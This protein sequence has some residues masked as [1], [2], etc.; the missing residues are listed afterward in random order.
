MRI[1][2]QRLD[3]V[4]IL[5]AQVVENIPNAPDNAIVGKLAT[6]DTAKQHYLL[7]MRGIPNQCNRTMRDNLRQT[8]PCEERKFLH[9]LHLTK[10]VL[11]NWCKIL[12]QFQYMSGSSNRVG[13]SYLIQPYKFIWTS[14]LPPTDGF[15]SLWNIRSRR[16]L[17]YTSVEVASIYPP[18]GTMPEGHG[19]WKVG[20]AQNIVRVNKG[21]EGCCTGIADAMVRE[22]ELADN[23]RCLA[24][25]PS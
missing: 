22:G 15:A 2:L 7:T 9:F 25:L 6:T 20:D 21:S 24:L 4:R 3:G 11:N 10:D 14:I 5:F 8:R 16:D 17:V 12:E 23:L 13:N 19:V 1:P 18:C